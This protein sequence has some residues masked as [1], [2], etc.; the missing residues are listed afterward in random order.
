MVTK[1]WLQDQI[2]GSEAEK[3]HLVRTLNEKAVEIEGLTEDLERRKSRIV[4]LERQVWSLQH[5][6]KTRDD[7]ALIERLGKLSAAVVREPDPRTENER[8]AFRL[9]I[10]EAIGRG[11][12]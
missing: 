1:V 9:I 4:E 11:Q 8:N 10:M 3:D 6:N 12:G 7:D 2:K 5:A